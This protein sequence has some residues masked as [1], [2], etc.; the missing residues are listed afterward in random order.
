MIFLSST[1]LDNKFN[2]VPDELRDKTYL[3]YPSSLPELQKKRMIVVQRWL[4]VRGIPVIDLEIQAKMYFLGWM[5]PGGF[6][7]MR[8]EFYRE[9]FLEGFDMM[10]D[11]DYAIPSTPV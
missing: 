6:R 7:H 3:T 10:V 5:L 1:L 2:A 8:S 9:Y 4:E 11:Q